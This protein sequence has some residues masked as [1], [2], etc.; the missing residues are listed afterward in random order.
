MKPSIARAGGFAL[1][2]SLGACR[3]THSTRPAPAELEGAMVTRCASVVR[4]P[5]CRVGSERSLSVFVPGGARHVSLTIDDQ[6]TAEAD[7]T[8]V[9]GRRFD[10]TVPAGATRLG[11]SAEVQGETRAWSRSI[12][13]APA[14]PTW[15]D[16]AR[17]QKERGALDDATTT[18][19][20]A[21][22][23]GGASD[24]R[25]TLDVASL[26]ARIALGRGD[27]ESAV[28]QLASTAEGHAARGEVSQAA[29]DLG[30]RAFVLIT[31]LRRA[32][33]ARETIDR[34][35]SFAND[36]AEAGALARFYA[37][38]L[39]S[40]TGDL[41]TSLAAL[42]EAR[43][44]A[45]RVGV[46]K[47]MRAVIQVDASTLL[48][49]GR[50]RE[51]H[52]L[53]LDLERDQ[54]ASMSA[55]ERG[56]IDLNVGWAALVVRNAPLAG[57][58]APLDPLAPLRRSAETFT[59]E[60]PNP[61]LH[62]SAL[63]NLAWADLQAGDPHGA[64]ASLEEA[65]AASDHPRPLLL[66]AE[67]EMEGRIALAEGDAH[68]ALRAY[69]ALALQSAGV[70]R[71]DEEA[72]EEGRAEAHR[73]LRE[74]GEALLAARRADAL[75]D[76]AARAIPA[77]DGR[78]AFWWTRARVARTVVELLLDANRPAEALDAARMAGAR[79]VWD[80]QRT[81][82]IE[83]LP[84]EFRARWEDALAT[85]RRARDA[86][87]TEASSDWSFAGEALARRLADRRARDV[88]MR[89][90]LDAEAT[91]VFPPVARTLA[92]LAEGEGVVG[93]A[94]VPL[95]GQWADFV[96]EG[97]AVRVTRVVASTDP[98]HAAE[99]A[100][101]VLGAVAGDLAR[102]RRVRLLPFGAL[103]G[104][105][106]AAVDV[107]GEP[108]L[109]HAP[110]E[111]PLDVGD[112]PRDA[113]H[114]PAT[115]GLVVADPTGTL[116][117]ARRE[118]MRV[119]AAQDGGAGVQI[120][121]GG[122]ATRARVVSAIE[123]ASWLHFAGH[124]SYEGID[125]WESA[126]LL[127]HD[128]RLTV[129]DVLA[130]SR[131]PARVVLSGCET[132]HEGDVAGGAPGLSLADAFLAAGSRAVV[133]STRVVDDRA[134]DVLVRAL[135]AALADSP[136]DV[137]SALRRAQLETRSALPSSDWSAFRAFVR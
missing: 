117:A 63:T 27:G 90:Q 137:A 96:V 87:V 72:A 133:A 3:A 106:L 15:L 59:H 107:R 84:A 25:F 78:G 118:G 40:E 121:L 116:P 112:V 126:L 34:L 69:D 79:V 75:L 103:R 95:E 66:F 43:A 109:A 99:A 115:S 26:R 48:S 92:P 125:G 77:G 31:D 54:G 36:Y 51:A 64:R 135:T 73:R 6:A 28:R 91:A 57:D 67:L 122:D 45:E 37:G 61:R 110:I 85:Y 86:I 24:D 12:A 123:R 108:L 22:R 47:I 32:A 7:T 100:P 42:G 39:A 114:A 93:V 124:A 119:A 82:R 65:R 35:A 58:D 111:Y 136:D 131:A 30:A 68:A 53:L 128:E 29:D 16:D 49:V 18:L 9:D 70:S 105:D 50:V 71:F 23:D 10:V 17:K 44:M 52:A 132:G 8:G 46:A 14:L 94:L 55:C 97:G 38:L 5:V 21:A 101:I 83:S 127:A 4:G 20:A 81:A 113:A 56:T 89:A 80:V 129:A 19:D 60:C 1:L 33:E 130:L 76:E 120:L 134:T 104:V 74:P 41:G 102:A 98:S 13:D 2:A 88:A 62:A 11:I